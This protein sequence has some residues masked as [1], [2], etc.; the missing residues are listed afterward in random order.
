MLLRESRALSERILSADQLS[1]IKAMAEAIESNRDGYSTKA[2]WELDKSIGGPG[3]YQWPLHPAVQPFQIGICR[4]VLRPLQYAACDVE[5]DLIRESRSV[6]H[7]CGMFLERLMRVFLC[8]KVPIYA[9]RRQT[10]GQSVHVT[11]RKKLVEPS[12][13]DALAI[14][15]ELYNKAKHDVNEDEDRA[16]LFTAGDALVVYFASRIVGNFLISQLR[17]VDQHLLTNPLR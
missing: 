4:D 9:L 8:A 16:R 12:A 7:F 11:L 17:P 10:L 5:H 2:I 15:T 14:I 3:G 6:V 1:S 13:G